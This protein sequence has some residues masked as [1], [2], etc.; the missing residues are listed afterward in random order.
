LPR[1][2]VEVFGV[3]VEDDQDK[4][5]DVVDSDGLLEQQGRVKVSWTSYR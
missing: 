2:R 3:D 4:A 5:P 1:T